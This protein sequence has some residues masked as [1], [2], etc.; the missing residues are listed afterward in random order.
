MLTTIR[1]KAQGWI[2]WVI[3]LL[4]SVP[5]ALWGI[6]EYFDAEQKVPVAKING[7]ELMS[8]DFQRRLQNQ[9]NAL[10][11]QFGGKLDNKIFETPAFKQ[12][13]LNEMITERLVAADVNEQNYQ[14]GDQELARF[15][16]SNPAFQVNGKFSPELYSQTVRNSGLS[17]AAFE[18]QVRMGSIIRQIRDGFSRSVISS[19]AEINNLLKLHQEKRDVTI[20]TLSKESLLEDV[21]VTDADIKEYYDANK[22]RFMTD[23]NVRVEYISLSLSDVASQIEPD[24]EALLAYYEEN[25]SQYTQVEQRSAQHILLGVKSDASED[26]IKAIESQAIDIARKAQEGSDFSEL[27]KEFSVDTISSGNGGDL[28]FFEQGVMD[29]AFDEKVFSM[30]KGEISLPVKSRFGFHVI[31]LNDVKP[32]TGKS[33]DEVKAEISKEYALKEASSRFGQMAEELQ[34]IVYEQPTSLQPAADA[35][36]LKVETTQ[37]FSRKG[38]EGITAKRPFIDSAFTEDVLLEG[39]NSEVVET[40]TDTLAALRLVEHREPQQKQLDDVS[41]EIK[42]LLLTKLSKKKVTEEAS[43]LLKAV[44]SGETTLEKISEERGLPLQAL[45]DVS[46]SAE[47]RVQGKLLADIFRS[48]VSNGNDSKISSVAMANGDYALFSVTKITEGNAEDAPENLRNQVRQAIQQRH[49]DDLFDGYERGLYETSDIEIH[50][51]K[52]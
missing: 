20:L 19:D 32:E 39:L 41:A 51:D 9:R 26:E 3:V 31:K 38:G 24:E 50:A 29:A 8:Q 14:I 16:R 47:T 40:D 42:Q 22:K 43:K 45:K 10:R 4:I 17:A 21:T 18:N 35:V 12:R 44:H 36:G 13:V 46:R 34:N 25:K 5:F 1:E 28:G 11:Q 27:A 2:A 23:E 52:L 7:N 6:N 15:L 49:G 37:W 48:P 30:Q 33:F